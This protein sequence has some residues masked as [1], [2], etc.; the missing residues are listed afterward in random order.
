MF[1]N[2]VALSRLADCG[3]AATRTEGG[4]TAPFRPYSAV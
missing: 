1:R 2:V 4:L 3:F